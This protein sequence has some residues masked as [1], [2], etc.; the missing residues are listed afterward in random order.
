L[1]EDVD[2]SEINGEQLSQL[3]EKICKD[4]RS[5]VDCVNKNK[6]SVHVEGFD[7]SGYKLYDRTYKEELKRSLS[8][9]VKIKVTN[10]PMKKMRVNPINIDKFYCILKSSNDYKQKTMEECDRRLQGSNLKEEVDI[11]VDQLYE[12]LEKFDS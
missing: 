7:E 12:N 4:F 2:F 11:L 6:L 10:E 5:L 1:G 8:D 9:L 3:S